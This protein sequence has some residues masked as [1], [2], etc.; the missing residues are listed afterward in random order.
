MLAFSRADSI[1]RLL[2]RQLQPM[3]AGRGRRRCS[4]ATCR[5]EIE[6]FCTLSKILEIPMAI[7]FTC[8]PV[9][10]IPF[11]IISSAVPIENHRIKPW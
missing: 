1:G 3:A 11:H 7:G 6:R 8:T 2:D 10:K 5:S 4:L 9:Q